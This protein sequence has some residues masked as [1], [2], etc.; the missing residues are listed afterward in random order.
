M[1]EYKE[2]YIAFIDVLGFKQMIKE[3]TCQEVVNVY[4]SI[5]SM[6]NCKK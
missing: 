1:D 2:Y 5:K 6:R 3:K 4:K